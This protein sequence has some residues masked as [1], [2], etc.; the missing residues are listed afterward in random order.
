MIGELAGGLAL[1][2]ARN[3]PKLCAVSD[4]SQDQQSGREEFVAEVPFRLGEPATGSACDL[5]AEVIAALGRSR[6]SIE[7]RL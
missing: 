4:S 6:E 1:V 7:Q 2:T 3:R 5:G